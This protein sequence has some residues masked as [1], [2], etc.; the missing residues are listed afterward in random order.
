MRQNFGDGLHYVIMDG[1]P[2]SFAS[3]TDSLDSGE[4]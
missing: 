4:G 3:P 1:D 2:G